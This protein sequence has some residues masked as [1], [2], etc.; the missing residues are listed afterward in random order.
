MY[1]AEYSRR[2][3]DVQ[4][5]NRIMEPA[6]PETLAGTLPQRYFTLSSSLWWLLRHGGSCRFFRL[7]LLFLSV[8]ASIPWQHFHRY[9]PGL[10]VFGIKFRCVSNRPGET[11]CGSANVF[12]SHPLFYSTTQANW[13]YN[14]LII[15]AIMEK[16]SSS[17]A[18]D[19]RSTRFFKMKLRF[20]SND[21]NICVR[22][23]TSFF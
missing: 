10:H 5:A 13:L 8:R 23:W 14:W 18:Y 3:S 4:T 9:W 16:L 7:L 12:W 20:D 19:Y 2:L 22:D 11:G 15:R 17:S 1:R 21:S 6:F